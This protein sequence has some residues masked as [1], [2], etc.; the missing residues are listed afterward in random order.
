MGYAK[1]VQVIMHITGINIY[2]YH[3]INA[4]TFFIII[5][6]MNAN[7]HIV[8]IVHSLFK[9]QL[10]NYNIIVLINAQ[11]IPY[12]VNKVVLLHAK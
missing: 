10:I 6:I 7:N 4:I 1:T 9:I 8:I 3:M 12:Q 11:L 5:H 2:A